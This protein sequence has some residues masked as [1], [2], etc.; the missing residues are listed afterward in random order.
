VSHLGSQISALADGQMSPATAERALAHVATC[1]RCAAELEAARAARRTVASA[2]GAAPPADLTARLLSLAGSALREPV[3][4]RVDPFA[5]PRVPRA[6]YGSATRLDRTIP[7]H[8]LTGDISGRSPAWRLAAG[9]LVG[10]GVVAVTLFVMGDGPAV[11]PSDASTQAFALLGQA[12]SPQAAVTAGPVTVSDEMAGGTVVAEPWRRVARDPADSGSASGRTDYLAWMRTHG[13]T[14][15]ARV[16]AG[17]SITSVR[18]FDDTL[19][20]DLAGAAGTLVMTQRH[21]RLDT[22][23]LTPA[24]RQ[25]LAD[26]TVYVLSSQ[27][28]HAAWQSGDTVVEVVSEARSVDAQVVMAQ[29]PATGYDGGVVARIRRGW[30]TMTRTISQP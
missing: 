14:A 17:W 1:A 27:P 5:A 21:G 19:E 28:W 22:D 6:T 13:W 18:L 24:E 20:V 26:R 23:A 3:G 8:T 29:F 10:L 9:S 15:P 2:D 25:V 11:L 7:P 4:E 16:P 12:T 30:G